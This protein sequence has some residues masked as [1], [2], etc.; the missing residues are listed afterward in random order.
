MSEPGSFRSAYDTAAG[1]TDRAWRWSA[2]WFPGGGKALGLLIG[3]VLLGLLI[4][5][6]ERSGKSTT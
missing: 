3:L 2:S 5:A 4:W 1:H 6:I